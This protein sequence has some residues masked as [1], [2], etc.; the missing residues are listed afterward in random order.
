[1]QLGLKN[2]LRLISL[3]PIL[4]I[5]SI[6]SYFVYESFLNYK[7]KSDFI[8]QANALQILIISAI[9]WVIA[10]IMAIFGYLLSNETSKNIK[11]LENVLK[12]AVKDIK[13]TDGNDISINLQ[14][15]SGTTKA[16]ELLEAIIEQTRKDKVVALEA[17][18]AWGRLA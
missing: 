8:L 13:D 14:S 3:L 16:Y 1:M 10:I 5:F 7:D 4:I 2:R 17:S 6:T 12:K 9:V 18:E 11:S 15:A